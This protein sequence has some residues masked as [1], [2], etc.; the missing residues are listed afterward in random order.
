M[1]LY[2][3]KAEIRYVLLLNFHLREM[4]EIFCVEFQRVPLKFHTKYLTHTLKDINLIQHWNFKSFIKF[5]A[6]WVHHPP[7]WPT[8][9]DCPLHLVQMITVDLEVSVVVHSV[10]HMAQGH[11]IL[12][13]S[14]TLYCQRITH[15]YNGPKHHMWCSQAGQILWSLCK[16]AI[17]NPSLELDGVTVSCNYAVLI[18]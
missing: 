2:D 6:P 5:L 11:F 7:E 12:C 4:R 1:R 14:D 18:N 9:G 16:V 3:L 17:P 8:Q 15:L 13:L 10:A